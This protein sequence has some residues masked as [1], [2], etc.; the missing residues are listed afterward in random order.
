M[1]L[2]DKVA[3]WE[4]WKGQGMMSWE[5]WKEVEYG[6][7]V[8]YEVE[9]C[10]KNKVGVLGRSQITLRRLNSTLRAMETIGSFGEGAQGRSFLLEWSMYWEGA[11]CRQST[12]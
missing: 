9:E 2:I 4:S 7:F 10:E 3:Y 8:Q 11:G 6:S 12:R 1:L 5:K